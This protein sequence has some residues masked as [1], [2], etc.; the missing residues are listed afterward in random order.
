MPF[1][2]RILG[3]EESTAN[4]ASPKKRKADQITD[5]DGTDGEKEEG[6]EEP[7]AKRFKVDKYVLASTA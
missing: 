4:S 6:E 2:Q 5:G 1:F 3:L 7:P